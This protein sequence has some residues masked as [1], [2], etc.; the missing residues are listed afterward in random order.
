M[1]MKNAT[2]LLKIESI[3]FSR[4]IK[5]HSEVLN[6][7]ME[8][9][10]S[11]DR[12]MPRIESVI[13]RIMKKSFIASFLL[14]LLMTISFTGCSTD[15]TGNENQNSAGDY[16]PTS[17]DN[18]WVYTQ[19][20][21]DNSIKIIETEEVNGVNYYKFDQLQ[22]FGRAV[23][24]S[25]PLSI[26]KNKGDYYIKAD[27]RNTTTNG[28][29]YKITGYEFLFFKDYLN[30]NQTWTGTYNYT[31]TSYSL[32]KGF[33]RAEVTYTG[34]ILEKGISLTVNGTV[35]K[36][37][38]KFRFTQIED[39]IDDVWPTWDNSTDY[40]IAKNVGIIKF[41]YEGNSSEHKSHIVK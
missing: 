28:V 12:R 19:K 31:T 27:E 14:S 34:E 22:I 7:E 25:Q 38:I 24:Y 17:V 41:S 3:Y 35:F 6:V 40:W 36:D 2:N 21:V 5:F 13:G 1:K 20:G 9:I 4:A 15:S 32:S 23:D 39:G 26:K 11:S 8:E 37:V 29:P 18:N 10:P 33:A 30:V 16:W